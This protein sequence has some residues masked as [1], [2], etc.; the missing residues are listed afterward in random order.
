MIH[1][2]TYEEMKSFLKSKPY[3]SDDEAI[4]DIEEAIYW[5]ASDYHGG[6]WSNL[7]KALCASPYKP[8]ILAKGIAEDSIAKEMYDELVEHYI[9]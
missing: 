6:M 3:N 9:Q 1:D 7:Y 2:P 4:V 8:S 5:F